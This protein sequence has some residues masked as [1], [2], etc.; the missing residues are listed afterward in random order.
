MTIKEHEKVIKMLIKNHVEEYETEGLKIKLSPLAFV[1]N[2]RATKS[3]D[4]SSS[5]ED[6]LYYSASKFKDKK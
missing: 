1:P 3:A 5:I 6:D 2:Y 4:V